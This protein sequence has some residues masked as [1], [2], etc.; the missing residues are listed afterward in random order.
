GAEIDA[1]LARATD[2][3]DFATAY[4][5]AESSRLWAELDAPDTALFPWDAASTYI[6]RPPFA[7][8]GEGSRLGT[9]AARPI[10][11]VGD[12]ITTDHISPAGAIP[13]TGEAGQY[14]IDRGENPRDLNVFSSRRGNWEV[15]LRG[16]FTN[17][18]VRNLLGPDI[19]PGSTV[20]PDGQVLPLWRA[21]ARYHAQGQ[22]VVIVAGERYGMG[23]SRDW[24]AK[25]AALLGARAVLAVSFER[26]HRTNLIGM[27]ILPLRL[28]EG[29]TPAALAL[30]VHDLIGID[31]D[32]AR[33]S[34]RSP[35]AVRIR[36]ADGRVE[37]IAATAAI[38]T[39][40]EVETLLK[41]GLLPLILRR[42]PFPAAV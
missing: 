36:R 28:P 17:R 8:F 39:S 33:I 27:G 29:V 2:A 23:S 16:L 32:P 42:L 7:S 14:L 19:L 38:E 6:R 3:G 12:D 31:A 18:N 24:A 40:L 21:A 41:G 35:V 30:S 9:Y 26:I 13:A 4:D 22:P 10:L 11:V 34:P 1:A 37:E 25:G 20:L 5:E 15:M